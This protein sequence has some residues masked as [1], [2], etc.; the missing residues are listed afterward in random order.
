ML[1][2]SILCIIGLVLA[3][4]PL[5]AADYDPDDYF[6]FGSTLYFGTNIVLRDEFA[7][8]LPGNNPSSAVPI[9]GAA[10]QLIRDGGDNIIS[11]PDAS[12]QP[13]GDDELLLT[14]HIGV[15]V[16][17]FLGEQGIFSVYCNFSDY[18]DILYARMFNSTDPATATYYGQTSFY[19]LNT[20]GYFG[21]RWFSVDE[22][23]LAR[24]DIPMDT[25]GDY[26][27]SA[28]AAGPYTG[29]EGSAILL[30]A[31][32][33]TDTDT[34]LSALVFVWDLDD[35]GVFD[36]AAGITV[37]F[38]WT[39]NVALEIGLKAVNPQS[40]TAGIAFSTVS[41]NNEQPMIEQIADQSASTNTLFTVSASYSDPGTS[42][43]HTVTVNWGDL[44]IEQDIP[45]S[46]AQISL[47]HIYTADDTYIV[48][49]TVYDDDG[50]SSSA[51]FQVTVN[52]TIIEPVVIPAQLAMTEGVLISWTER[53][54][55]HYEIWFRDNELVAFDMIY[56]NWNLIDVVSGS[57]YTDTGDPDGFDDT[58]D[59]ADDRLHPHDT[60][61]RF[62]IVL[63]VA[64]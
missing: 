42:D 1:K 60:G 10:I 61:S 5:Y 16:P 36:D 45:V 53:E 13:T 26:V 44:T 40:G 39:D 14:T 59:T 4:H 47:S 49:I 21:D 32:G 25:Q 22:Y 43:T 37:N 27:A 58:P 17:V 7:A 18:D 8:V 24:T 20:S 52:P 35:D 12:G 56:P 50:A 2:K 51:M 19:A 46:G 23:G 15:G 63:E 54:G 29:N 38:A 64:D 57:S 30:D 9:P 34:D 41:I 62:Y 48:D 31:R 33:S 28:H 55:F 11:P 6:P 3:I